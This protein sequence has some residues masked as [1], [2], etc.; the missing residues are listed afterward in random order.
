MGLS[1]SD[2]ETMVWS[3]RG[4]CVVFAPDFTIVAANEAYLEAAKQ[5]RALVIGKTIVEAFP[6]NPDAPDAAGPRELRASI[7]RVLSTR[8]AERLPVARYDI[9]RPEEDGGGFEERHR[10]GFTYPVLDDEGR[11]GYLIHQ[12]EDVTER[13]LSSVDGTVAD[14]TERRRTEEELRASE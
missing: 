6:E 9:R 10:D 14:V 11:V 5:T 13:R 12:F 7:E 4:P 3:A 1:T 8:A 2:L